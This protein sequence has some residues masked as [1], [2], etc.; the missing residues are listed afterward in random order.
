M[1]ALIFQ[2]V[3]VIV[4]ILLIWPV[5]IGFSTR[6]TEEG[7]GQLGWLGYRFVRWTDVERVEGYYQFS[8]HSGQNKIEFNLSI[9]EDADAFLL[10]IQHRVPAQTEYK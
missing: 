4:G 10:E 7:I 6:V 5:V 2:V 3:S 1:A 8:I 9:L